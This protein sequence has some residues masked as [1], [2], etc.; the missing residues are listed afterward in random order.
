MT[1]E[2]WNAQKSLVA[3]LIDDAASLRFDLNQAIKAQIDTSPYS[4]K[5]TENKTG[6]R[7]RLAE[8]EALLRKAE[9]DPT[10]KQRYSSISFSFVYT[11]VIDSLKQWELELLDLSKQ[12]DRLE[13]LPTAQ[14]SPEQARMQLL[15]SRKLKQQQQAQGSSSRGA[16]ESL[17]INIEDE[18][19]HLDTG[20]LVQ[21][22]NR[23]IDDQ[24]AHLDM[25]GDT[26]LRQKAIGMQIGDELDLH[27][28]LLQ[29]TDTAVERTQ[30]RLG[31]VNNR[32]GDV[33]QTNK[34]DYR[35]NL[36]IV[37]LVLI[38]VLIVFS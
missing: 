16:A 31:N 35:S 18:T 36:I 29:Q 9:N 20:E 13:G 33:I 38:L 12:V 30:T 15:Q 24:D 23:M 25:L 4:A 19:D 10:L 5:I 27:V 28:D 1:S 17:S 21:L 2:S 11:H 3:S 7:L 6:L 37:V 8:M 22:Q 14:I 32:V 34:T 26:L